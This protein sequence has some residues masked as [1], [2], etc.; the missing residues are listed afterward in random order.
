MPR[1]PTW[2]V[3]GASGPRSNPLSPGGRLSS[4]SFRPR[5]RLC[6]RPAPRAWEGGGE[7]SLRPGVLIGSRSVTSESPAVCTRPRLRLLRGTDP[8]FYTEG[9]NQGLDLI[10]VST[11][12]CF[13]A[14]SGKDSVPCSFMALRVAAWTMEGLWGETGGLQPAGSALPCVR[15]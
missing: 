1:P 15:R 13:T 7:A 9:T 2:A 11:I 10:V 8:S 5:K 4:G 6:P 3:S 12:F 14:Y